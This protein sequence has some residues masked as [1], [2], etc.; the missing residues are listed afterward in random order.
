MLI[1][2]I[3]ERLPYKEREGE[4]KKYIAVLETQVLKNFL[5]ATVNEGDSR[6]VPHSGWI[7]VSSLREVAKS[8]LHLIFFEICFAMQ[9]ASRNSVS[10]TQK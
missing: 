3:R 1:Y 6:L 4:N 5:N 9:A 2:T 8:W 10:E 7:P